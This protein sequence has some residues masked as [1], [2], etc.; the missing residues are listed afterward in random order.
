MQVSLPQRF[1]VGSLIA[2]TV[3]PFP[4][5]GR[6]QD[7]GGRLRAPVRRVAAGEGRCRRPC[8]AEFG[9]AMSELMTQEQSLKTQQRQAAERRAPPWRPTSAPRRRKSC[10]TARA[11]SS[12]RRR[13]LQDDFNAKRNEEM[14]KLQRV[15]FDEVRDYAKAQNFDLVIAEGVHLCDAHGRHHGRR[16]GGAAVACATAAAGATPAPAPPKP[17]AKP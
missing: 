10:A 6:S 12:A 5:I 8:A 17:P 3:L 2:A 9:R 4:R 1:F 7:R 14:Y 11:R 16:A 13:E 15:L